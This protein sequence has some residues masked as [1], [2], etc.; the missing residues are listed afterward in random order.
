MIP[1]PHLVASTCAFPCIT[2]CFLGPLGYGVVPAFHVTAH[3]VTN[4]A[5]LR[6]TFPL[7]C[8]CVRWIT[9]HYH[10]PRYS[11]YYPLPR[12]GRCTDLLPSRRLHLDVPAP[13]VPHS[14]TPLQCYLVVL[15]LTVI[16]T[17]VDS[18]H[19][20]AGQPLWLRS[21]STT[22][23]PA[24][25]TPPP[26]PHPLCSL[27]TVGLPPNCAFEL[28]I[29]GSFRSYLTVNFT[30]LFPPITPCW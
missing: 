8:W 25:H 14:V 16:V 12:V 29:T 22:H 26:F 27:F 19:Y 30:L 13:F 7:P 6:A 23:F 15:D 17:V 18:S 4:I 28:F 1:L 2:D 20:L 9:W 10:T 21:H 24:L 11:L 3:Y 5:P